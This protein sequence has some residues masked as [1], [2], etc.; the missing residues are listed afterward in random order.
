MGIRTTT[1]DATKAKLRTL[2]A[3]PSKAKAS[4]YSDNR[5][6]CEVAMQLA[7]DCQLYG[8]WE[9]LLY[10]ESYEASGHYATGAAERALA[11]LVKKPKPVAPAV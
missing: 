2:R 4:L 8:V 3:M 6:G 9:A 11:T 7:I 10:V 1:D 5:G